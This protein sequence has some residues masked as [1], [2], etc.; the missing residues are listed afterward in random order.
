MPEINGTPGRDLLTGTAD[1]DVISGGEGGD[2]INGGGGADIIYGF[3]ASDVGGGAGAIDATLIAAGLFN[4]VFAASPPGDPN[5][6]FIIEQHRGTIRILDLSSNQMLATPFLDIADN[7][8]GASGEEGLLG[9]AFHPSYASNGLYY[10]Y[11]TNAA[12][13][14]EIWQ[15]TRGANPDVSSTTRQLVITINHPGQSNHNGGWIA[16]GPDGYLYVATGDG[17]GGG[18]PG[19]N[20]QNTNSLLGKILRID[21]NS[22]GFPTD[23]GRN[24]AIPGDNP[25]VGVAGADEVFAIGLRNPWRPSF[26]TATGDMLIA[27]VG[28]GAREEINFVPAGTLAGRNFGWV[29]W[30]GTQIYD[31]T[32]SGNPPANSPLFTHPIHDYGHGSG[33]EQGFSV[34]GGYVIRGPDAGGQGLYVFA[35]FITGNFWT[36]RATAGG[37]ED[38]ARRNDQL[39]VNG[40][41]F[42]QIASFALDGQG[43]LYGV[44]LD[45]QIHRLTFNAGAGDVGDVLYGGDGGDEIYG[46]LGADTITGGSGADTIGAGAGNDTINYN[47]GDGVDAIDGGAGTDTIVT[48][49]HAGGETLDVIW[50]GSA[51]TA[52]KG[53]AVVSVEQAIADMGAGVDWLR[54]HNSTLAVSINLATGAASGFLSIANIE[55]AWGSA[56]NDTL[57]GSSVATILRGGAGDDAIDGGAG[58]DTIVGDDGA[59][60]INGGDDADSIYGLSGADI[61]NGGNGD[62]TINYSFGEGVDS[63]DGGAGVDTIVCQGNSGAETLEVAWNGTS[64]TFFKG[65]AVSSIE[66]AIAD[67]GLGGDWLRYTNSTAAVGVNLGANTA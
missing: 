33:P 25:Y 21:V 24:Y 19:N 18:D 48:Q 7:E 37:A 64:F 66:Q 49:G 17:G 51:F 5:R 27:D 56:F 60:A 46:G 65:G 45:G 61:V 50:N 30:E 36:L 40:G 31:D 3:G 53:G 34:T 35:D 55:N 20:A 42:D 43:R 23:A 29:V 67:M 62:D 28:Q 15:Y 32:R 41:D 59:D 54:H 39:V 4:P 47:F 22:D 12:G 52:F 6:F 10:I 63:I 57:T 1:A 16:F 14:N 11:V 2:T 8:L 44:G 26:D 13:N 38:V 58:N 9:L